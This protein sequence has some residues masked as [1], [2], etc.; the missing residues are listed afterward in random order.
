MVVI[1]NLDSLWWG[2]LQGMGE[3]Q[4]GKQY[5]EDQTALGFLSVTFLEA[6]ISS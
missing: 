4:F 6:S 5:I 3:R 1:N 2:P